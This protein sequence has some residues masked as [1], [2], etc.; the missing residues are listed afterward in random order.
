[1]NSTIE[2]QNLD[3]NCNNC[4]YMDRDI[5]KFKQSLTKHHRWQLDYFNMCRDNMLTKAKEWLG[6]K[7]DQKK[8]DFIMAEVKKLRFQFDKST[9]AINYGYCT[10]KNKDV[11]FIPNTLQLDTQGC[12]E[13]R[14]N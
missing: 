11:T 14:K 13:N 5:E 1:M 2:L 3:C 6:K 7:G 9:C 8:H 10:K 12:F 4:L